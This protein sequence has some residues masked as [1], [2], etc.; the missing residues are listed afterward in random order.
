RIGPFR[1]GLA[2]EPLAPPPCWAWGGVPDGWDL[3]VSEEF[4]DV[5]LFGCARR[6]LGSLGDQTGHRF[7]SPAGMCAHALG[8]VS[9]ADEQRSQVTLFSRARAPVCLVSKG[10]GGPLGVACAPQRTATLKC[11]CTAGSW[12]DL[13][14]LNGS[15]P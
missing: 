4:G 11:T 5:R 10:L 8:S 13:V 12:P 6:P 9:V 7:G 14:G 15:S 3:A 2:L 1:T